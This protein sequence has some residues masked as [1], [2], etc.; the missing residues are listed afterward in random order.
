MNSLPT[1]LRFK[2]SLSILLLAALG[3]GGA[4]CDMI[5]SQVRGAA[6]LPP[7]T[8]ATVTVVNNGIIQICK[9]HVADETDAYLESY[10]LIS[11]K[12]EY[13]G[14]GAKHSF[15]VMLDG[16]PKKIRL[17]ACDSTVLKELHDVALA[18]G[19]ALQVMVP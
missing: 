19:G 8:K 7:V 15:E 5:G 16:K 1:S 4:G 10:S 6:G 14:P 13:L 12:Y 18:D 9:M 2:S 17:S 3:F 11:T